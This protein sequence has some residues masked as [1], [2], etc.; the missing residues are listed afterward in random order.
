MRK[1]ESLQVKFWVFIAH[2]PFLCVLSLQERAEY[3][4]NDVSLPYYFCII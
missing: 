3:R 2:F 1:R 4:I